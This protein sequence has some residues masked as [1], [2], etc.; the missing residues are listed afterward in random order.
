MPKIECPKCHHIF[1][2]NEVGVSNFQKQVDKAV[3]AREK[4]IAKRVTLET[5]Q[6]FNE[7][8]SNLEK[9]IARLKTEHALSLK[10]EEAKHNVEINKLK[11]Q[12]D[13][14]HSDAKDELNKSEAK[15]RVQL[16]NKD[17]EI[18]Y[19]NNN[20]K[21]R[22]QKSLLDVKNITEKYEN[23]LKDKDEQVAYYRDL[24]AKLSTKMVGETLE[25]HCMI[26]F[27]KIRTSAFPN[28]YFEKDNT[29]SDE[30]KSKGDFIF[31]DS[32]DDTEYI[33]IMFEMKNEND[34]TATKKT[35]DH[36][37]KELD[38]DRKEKGCEYAV[39]V[40][41]LEPENEFYNAGIVDVS[42]RYPKMFVIRP[43]CFITLIMLLTNAAKHS[44]EY[45]KQLAEYRNQNFDAAK[46]EENLNDFRTKFSNNYR[47]AGDHFAAAIKEIDST[48]DHLTKVRNEL[49]SSVKNLRLANDKL[50]E[51]TIKKLTYN[52][53]TMKDAFDNIKK[54]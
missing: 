40:S 3:E 38:K 34:K 35:N 31:R 14:V 9:E 41:L 23:K 50:Q 16:M 19:L 13:K 5:Q 33:S 37:L 15:Y 52:N 22:E 24:K 7:K 21:L 18:L 1:E 17:K 45:K 25:Q 36:F 27:N 11:E 43:Q 26:E 42:Y 6:E 39:L 32:I 10:D 2:V 53:P 44:A 8:L 46:F 29:V 48:I 4:E 30:S 51:L 20:M 12:I 28:A 54:K 47:Y 49:T